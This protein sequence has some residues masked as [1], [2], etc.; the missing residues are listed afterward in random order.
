MI[1]GM[2]GRDSDIVNLSRPILVAHGPA[3][4]CSLLDK[5]QSGEILQLPEQLSVFSLLAFRS[6]LWFQA[7]KREC[8]AGVVCIVH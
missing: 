3:A 5:R 8:A 2:C 7:F 6:I 4:S 1:P